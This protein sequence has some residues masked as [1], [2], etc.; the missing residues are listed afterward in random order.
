MSIRTRLT[1]WYTGLLAV[2]LLV[3]NVLV[4]LALQGVLIKRSRIAW[5][6]SWCR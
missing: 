6:S 2:F 4:Y 5:P 1:L 3:F